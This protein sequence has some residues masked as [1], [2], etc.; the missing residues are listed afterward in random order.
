VN[1]ATAPAAAPTENV[2]EHPLAENIAEGL[3]D[4]VD[5]GEV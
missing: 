4:V 1:T 5:I 3:E 2:A